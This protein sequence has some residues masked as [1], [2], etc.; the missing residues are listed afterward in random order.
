MSLVIQT[1]EC[2]CQKT[3]KQTRNPHL[4]Y[5]LSPK[6][7][8]FSVSK[9]YW[10]PCRG[11]GNK[12]ELKDQDTW[13][14]D[15]GPRPRNSMSFC[16][17]LGPLF[18]IKWKFKLMLYLPKRTLVKLEGDSLLE[19]NLHAASYESKLESIPWVIGSPQ[20]NMIW[21]AAA[22]RQLGLFIYVRWVLYINIVKL[23]SFPFLPHLWNLLWNFNVTED[24][25][26][27]CGVFGE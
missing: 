14:G 26:P 16:F 19:N 2:A 8:Y 12:A 25:F 9:E 3:K 11:N 21:R 4:R 1:L 13:R 23:L 24:S 15:I 18:S 6:T 20:G 27:L 22:E 17:P 5:W 7:I 10:P